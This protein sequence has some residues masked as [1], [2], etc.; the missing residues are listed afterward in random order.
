MVD[1]KLD[2]NNLEPAVPESPKF[3]MS[4]LTKRRAAGT[5]IGITMVCTARNAA[6]FSTPTMTKR[7]GR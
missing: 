4:S 7:S 2:N 3:P 1:K 6:T 5:P